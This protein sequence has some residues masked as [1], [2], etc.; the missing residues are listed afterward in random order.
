M[1]TFDFLALSHFDKQPELTALEVFFQSITEK[2]SLYEHH[3][4]TTTNLYRTEYND[5]RRQ[6]QEKHL[7]IRKLRDEIYDKVFKES[8]DH[9]FASHE[10]RIDDLEE[11]FEGRQKNELFRFTEMADYFNKSSVVVFYSFLES[12]LRSLCGLLKL[13]FEK[14]IDLENLNDKNYLQA[15]LTYFDLVIDLP[16]SKLQPYTSKFQELQFLRNK[17]VH[18]GAE[19]SNDDDGQRLK[20][21]VARSSNMLDLVSGSSARTKILKIKTIDYLLPYYTEL[22]LFFYDL[23]CLI[24]S[25]CNHSIIKSKLEFLFSFI[26][27]DVIVQINEF[28]AIK[29][30]TQIVCYIESKTS[31]PQISIQCKITLIASPKDEVEIIDQFSNK[32]EMFDRLFSYMQENPSLTI[33]KLFGF[34]GLRSMTSKIKMMFYAVD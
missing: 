3:C 22:K 11:D 29:K 18:N 26:S 4:I 21:I 24:E 15:I 2:V 19:F 25:K 31:S 28:K 8:G 33:K 9:A 16:I 10:S 20:A 12:E 32:N 34:F 14:R 5:L 1:Y 6:S 23:F 7:A 17:I 13:T 30:G 27:E